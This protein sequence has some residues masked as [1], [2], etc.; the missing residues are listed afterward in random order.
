MSPRS[1]RNHEEII[2]GLDVGEFR[3]VSDARYCDLLVA[4]G[5]TAICFVC[6]ASVQTPVQPEQTISQ[7]I[8][9]TGD[10]K[11][12]CIEAK[13]DGRIDAMSCQLIDTHTGGVK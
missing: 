1:R 12:L 9:T 3:R 7:R 6:W 8:E 10:A 11:R 4:S 13:T 5:L 2:Q